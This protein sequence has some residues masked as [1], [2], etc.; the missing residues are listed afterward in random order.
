MAPL[1]RLTGGKSG[2]RAMRQTLIIAGLLFVAAAGSQLQ[3]TSYPVTAAAGPW[4]I[5]VQSYQGEPSA[6][7]A[8]ELCSSLRRDYKIAAYVFNKGEEERQKERQ[9]IA[10]VRIRMR[11]QMKARGLPDDEKL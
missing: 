3:A 6:Q 10:E 7:L 8:E 5:L 2:D 1:S 11:D 9:R 4:M